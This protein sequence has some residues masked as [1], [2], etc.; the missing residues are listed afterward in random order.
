VTTAPPLSRGYLPAELTDPD[1]SDEVDLEPLLE[2]LRAAARAR[3]GALS[4]PVAWNC[5]AFGYDLGSRRYSSDLI[6]PGTLPT[7][8][9][10]A[11]T[12]PLPTGALVALTT[13]AG[14][15]A[16][17]VVHREGAHA[18][19]DGDGTAPGWLSGAPA[20]AHEPT[21]ALDPATADD[22]V[23]GSVLVD[24][25][26]TLDAFALG[27]DRPA[28]LRRLH[29]RWLDSLGHLHVRTRYRSAELAEQSEV[30]QYTSYLIETRA[31][32]AVA[33]LE[34]VGVRPLDDGEWTVGQLTTRLQTSML[35]VDELL[36]L[37]G[38]VRWRD[39]AIDPG[40][41]DTT[42]DE[43]ARDD[44]DRLAGHLA[45]RAVPIK[46]RH[47]TTAAKPAHLALGTYLRHTYG[48]L[49]PEKV[50]GRAYPATLAAA[51]GILTE[52]LEQQG[53]AVQ[54]GGQRVH[55]RLDDAWQG[56]GVW[57]ATV[58]A[59][60]DALDEV[61][62]P[63]SLGW[64]AATAPPA[65]IDGRTVTPV[66]TAPT[67]GSP[68]GTAPSADP[69]GASTGDGTEAGSAPDDRRDP[70]GQPDERPGDA[71]TSPTADA[72]EQPA[73]PGAPPPDSGAEP[74]P[75]TVRS[76]ATTCSWT[77]VL[78]NRHHT[79]GT[80]PL[81]RLIA[82]LME[83]AGLRNQAVH[84]ML[85][86]PGTDIAPE[87]LRHSAQVCNRSLTGLRWPEQ[88]FVGLKLTASWIRDGSIISIES[89]PLEEPKLCDGIPLEYD[90][91]EEVLLR[92]WGTPEDVDDDIDAAVSP[93]R[94]LAL[95]RAYAR[96][97][98][99]TRPLALVLGLP[100]LHRL[101]AADPTRTATVEDV[102][103]AVDALTTRSTMRGSVWVQW[104]R[105]TDEMVADEPYRR[106]RSTGSRAAALPDELAVLL[107]LA[108]KPSGTPSK[109]PPAP[110]A[111]VAGALRRAHLRWNSGPVSPERR[112]M[113]LEWATERGIDPAQIHPYQTF[114]RSARVRAYR[115]G[116]G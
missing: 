60:G 98:P 87:L 13:G 67:G 63:L 106:P 62:L 9:I 45:R 99:E 30:R 52:R 35:S 12:P 69:D 51:S 109:A 115:R 86:H 56:G 68:A 11:V 28:K 108:V 112:Q 31:D 37:A 61:D 111:T 57:R 49:A 72:A 24:E 33:L 59:D 42:L 44:L 92:S 27:A 88:M 15:V 94:V 107:S 116:G 100:E 96:R 16:A 85:S 19:L 20:G 47:G 91:D 64:F 38:L 43:D 3:G 41:F 26:L 50:T 110:P 95:L 18:Q 79:N 34:R 113:A 66:D 32:L 6:D 97:V 29:G 104:A 5:L 101:T 7:V 105:W 22:A 36:T 4:V 21:G 65:G 77:F 17:E 46:R 90:F 2:Y 55:L 78:T 81:T 58:V 89:T 8:T 1:G 103:R 53:R 102:A 76:D 82:E 25:L 75:V 48:D 39:Q 73:A 14:A 84:V 83:G 114:V 40:V 54:V 80:V 71:D 93:T 74:D 23:G 70:D 10:D